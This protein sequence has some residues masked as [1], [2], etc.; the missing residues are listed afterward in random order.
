MRRAKINLFL[1]GTPC[2]V[3]TNG[4]KFPN[5]YFAKKYGDGDTPSLPIEEA[6]EASSKFSLLEIL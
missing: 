6:R 2:G 1:E 5:D 3:Q 4:P